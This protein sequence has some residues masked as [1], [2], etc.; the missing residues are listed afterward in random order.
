MLS[1][2]DQV[3]NALVDYWCPA[4]TPIVIW[5]AG[6]VDTEGSFQEATYNIVEENL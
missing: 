1:A 4:F 3:R 6:V 2:T 5:F